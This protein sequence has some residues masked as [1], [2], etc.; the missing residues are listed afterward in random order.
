MRAVV[1]RVSSSKVTV[2]DRVTG[3]INKGLLVLLGVTHEDTSKDVDYMIDKILNLRIFEDENEKM[4][5]S[6]KDVGGE[7]LVVSQFTLYGDCRKGKRPSF[8]NAARPDVA[9]K[10]YEEFVQKAKNNDIVVGTGEF[11]AHMMV[12]LTN[13]G[14]VTILLESNKAF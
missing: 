3:Q 13:D 5:L 2:G 9:T 6:L 8:T 7:L 10:L 1:Q 12:D 11:G 14:P 4:N